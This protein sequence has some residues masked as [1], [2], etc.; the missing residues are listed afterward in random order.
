M[1][2]QYAAPLVL[3][4]LLL[5]WCLGGGALAEAGAY[6]VVIA[7]SFCVGAA[8]FGL[9]AAGCFARGVPII[10][11]WAIGGA[12]FSDLVKLAVALTVGA[13]LG[14]IVIVALHFASSHSPAQVGVGAHQAIP[15]WR[16]IA[17]AF[18]SAAISQVVFRLFVESVTIWT[19]AAGWKNQE[20]GPMA[21][22]LCI[23][24]GA[25]FSGLT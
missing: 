11:E 24:V 12:N 9:G 2:R 8:G 23:A 7:S 25:T 18:S 22:R 19:V 14:A 1:T 3:L 6:H 21:V 4:A 20:A 10:E 13:L 16:A 5:V 15:F 17:L